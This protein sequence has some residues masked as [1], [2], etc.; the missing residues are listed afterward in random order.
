MKAYCRGH[1]KFTPKFLDRSR[2]KSPVQTILI[3]LVESGLVYLGIQVCCFGIGLLICQ[4]MI[5]TF[6]PLW[7]TVYLLISVSRTGDSLNFGMNGIGPLYFSLAVS[8]GY[9]AD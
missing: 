8:V 5:L 2:R 6:S 1:R 9:L 7:Q 3:L 4:R